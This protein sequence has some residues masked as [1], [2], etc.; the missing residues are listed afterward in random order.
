MFFAVDVYIIA[1]DAIAV[2]WFG[3]IS[4]RYLQD[5]YYQNKCN[6]R[7]L[8]HCVIGNT[9]K[10]TN[11]VLCGRGRGIERT[12]EQ[13]ILY[14]IVPC[15]FLS[16]FFAPTMADYQSKCIQRTSYHSPHPINAISNYQIH[17]RLCHSLYALIS[18]YIP[19]LKTHQLTSHYR[20]AAISHYQIPLLLLSSSSNQRSVTDHHFPII[21]YT[22]LSFAHMP[23]NYYSPPL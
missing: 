9:L 12:N 16:T 6:K 17:T 2:L 23:T 10:Q 18:F 1:A 7:L 15:L 20:P 5:E 21:K 14:Y 22:R 11:N 19:A 8:F 4:R 3:E 13:W